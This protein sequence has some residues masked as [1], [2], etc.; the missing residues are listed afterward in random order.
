MQAFTVVIAIQ[1]EAYQVASA[2]HLADTVHVLHTIN[3]LIFDLVFTV[4]RP[5]VPPPLAYPIPS[6]PHGLYP[7]Q[8]LHNSPRSNDLNLVLI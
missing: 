1:V 4:P 2:C 5:N 3:A 8:H 6:S 7:D